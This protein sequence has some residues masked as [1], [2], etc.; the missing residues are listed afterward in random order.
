MGKLDCGSDE[1]SHPLFKFVT[2]RMGNGMLG[3]SIKW[4][5]TKFLC[6]K[7]GIPIKRY[8]PPQSPLSFEDDIIEMLRT[9]SASPEK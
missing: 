2:Q 9:T 3:G 1:D 4:N 8:G 5:F 7:E 6:D